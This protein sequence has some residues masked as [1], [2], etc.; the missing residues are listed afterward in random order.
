[1]SLQLCDLPTDVIR[2]IF[3]TFHVMNIH[4]VNILFERKSMLFT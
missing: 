2:Q 4:K 1:M 3:I